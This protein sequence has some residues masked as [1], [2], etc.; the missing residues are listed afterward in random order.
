MFG[1]CYTSVPYLRKYFCFLSD[2]GVLVVC[3]AL[4][5]TEL[6]HILACAFKPPY[7]RLPIIAELTAILTR[8]S[9]CHDITRA[10][11]GRTAWPAIS[12]V[13]RARGLWYKGSQA[14]S[15]G[16]Q[17]HGTPRGRWGPPGY[18]LKKRKYPGFGQAA[19]LTMYSLP[20]RRDPTSQK[21]P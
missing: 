10:A 3:T 13:V 14:R 2:L 17:G 16:S 18:A 4:P 8:G 7:R 20:M 1:R 12:T 15:M 19:L 5:M 21:A 9:N 11:Q 6:G